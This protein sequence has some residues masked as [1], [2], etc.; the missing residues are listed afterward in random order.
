MIHSISLPPTVTV[1]PTYVEV[2]VMTD[3]G[4]VVEINLQRLRG[5]ASL[6]P[7]EFTHKA[8]AMALSALAAA[9]KSLAD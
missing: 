9:A 5:L 8:Q 4:A 1:G 2:S 7:E 6:S 3:D